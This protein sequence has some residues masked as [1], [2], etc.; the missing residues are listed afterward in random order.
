MQSLAMS[1]ESLGTR[2][3][4]YLRHCRNCAVN[5]ADCAI[6]SDGFSGSL[7]FICKRCSK[8]IGGIVVAIVFVLAHLVAVI[9]AVSYLLSTE[10]DRGTQTRACV[11]RLMRYIPMQSVKVVIVTWQIVIQVR[12]SGLINLI[13]L[14]PIRKVAFS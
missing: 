8:S 10:L 11:E 2:P 4:G 13:P 1:L 12:W 14:C 6:C 7:G 5:Q 3:Y 9:L